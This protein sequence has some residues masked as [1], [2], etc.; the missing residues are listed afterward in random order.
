MSS[1][2]TSLV[3]VS[4]LGGGLAACSPPPAENKVVY[5]MEAENDQGWC[6]PEAQSTAPGMLTTRAMFDPLTVPDE[7]GDYVPFLAKAVTPN[8]DFT[9]WTITLREGVQ[10]HDGSPLNA[11][12]VK[13]NL[14]AF[15]GQYPARNPLLF[16]FTFGDIEDVN[17][18]DEF[19]VVVTTKVPWRAFPAFLNLSNRFG[20]MAQSQLDN[21]ETCDTEPIG[22]GP[23]MLVDWKPGNRLLLK[24][25]P[26]YWMKGYP[27]LD[28]LE[29]RPMPDGDARR[30]A[31]QG[32]EIDAMHTSDDLYVDDFKPEVA[33][34]NLNM[35]DTLKFTEL[36]YIMMNT[37]KL[38]FSNKNARL[39]LAHGGD[40][41][42]IN[43]AVYAG[44][45]EVR[46]GPYPEGS[47]GYV[48][49]PGF[50]EYDL[51]KAKEYA[52]KYEEETGEPLEF[53]LSI[54][55]SVVALGQLLQQ[56]ASASGATINLKQ[57]DQAQLINGAINGDF[58][59]MVFRN[60][61]GTEPDM[62]AV[63]WTDG[64]VNFPR[65]NAK[66]D[67]GNWIQPGGKV[68]NDLLV[69]ARSEPDPAKRT[70]LY[71]EVNRTFASEVFN[72]WAYSSH[73]AVVTAPDVEGIL[74]TNNPDGSAPFPGL[75]TAHPVHALCR[76]GVSCPPEAEVDSIPVDVE[77]VG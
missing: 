75:A 62:Q 32:G 74:G 65:F 76:E 63:W 29:F 13:N 27:L 73:W 61:P 25:N 48:A 15:R 68:I 33:G 6:L 53:E 22:T 24:K 10:F 21:A 59:A 60:H 43:Q 34:G 35:Y 51:D 8:D 30:N 70:K 57:L 16:L 56:L 11:A 46:E 5:G 41:A 19:N 7:N 2:V 23:F 67:Q 4:V 20:V 17:V 45:A 18:A 9:E 28:E 66:D 40:R 14:D 55:P 72:I 77:T 26:N 39:A 3:A 36:S 1:V 44:L 31:L 38:P 42:A 64:P 50:P 71:E 12:V 58:D 69:E 49:D 54:I 52:R 47:P 37:S